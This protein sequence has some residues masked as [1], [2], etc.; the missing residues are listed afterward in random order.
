[1]WGYKA[2]SK[3]LLALAWLSLAL[4]IQ[5]VPLT[6]LGEVADLAPCCPALLIIQKKNACSD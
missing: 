3:Y 6:P 4:N 5:A 1:M 2:L